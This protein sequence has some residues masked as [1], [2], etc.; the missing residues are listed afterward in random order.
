[1]CFL[2]FKPVWIFVS[3]IK[4]IIIIIIW[5]EN[6]LTLKIFLRSD[7]IRIVFVERDFVPRGNSMRF[8]KSLP[9]FRV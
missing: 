8:N 2:F 4:I 9:D 7:Q 5:E 6:A 1:M 3:G